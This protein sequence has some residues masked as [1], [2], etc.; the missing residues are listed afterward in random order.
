MPL[1][2]IPFDLS[3]LAA[4]V[5]ATQMSFIITDHAQD[6]EPIIFCNPAFEL[7]TGYDSEEIIGRNCRF[8]QGDDRNQPALKELRSAT[9]DDKECT[10]IVRNYRKDGTAFRNELFIS[11][12]RSEEGK[13]THMIGI[14]RDLTLAKPGHD[15]AD[16]FLHDWRTPLTIIKSTL[17]LLHQ[18]GLTVDPVFMNKSLGSA[19]SAI[20]RMEKL[21]R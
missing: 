9:A 19:I 5:A 17:Q 6:D 3:L 15:L 7:M 2:E 4:A 10:V 16:Q 8:L 12:V 20:E 14:Q 13:V 1:N 18:K 21:G 11:P